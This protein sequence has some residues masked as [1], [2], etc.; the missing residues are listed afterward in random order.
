MTEGTIKVGGGSDPP[1]DLDPRPGQ[2]IVGNGSGVGD[3]LVVIPVIL[4]M[5]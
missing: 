5:R 4:V 2:I 3:P 1:T